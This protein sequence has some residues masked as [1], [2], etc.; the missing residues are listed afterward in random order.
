MLAALDNN[1]NIKLEQV[2]GE[3]GKSTVVGNFNG[4]NT[5]KLSLRR[6]NVSQKNFLQRFNVM[7]MNSP[8]F[9]L[10]R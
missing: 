3:N 8:Q 10:K 9:L 6:S 2:K 1:S 5:A 4:P 7:Y